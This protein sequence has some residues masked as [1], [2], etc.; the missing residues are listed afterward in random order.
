MSTPRTTL[1]VLPGTLNPEVV[2]KHN[3]HHSHV[4]QK[5]CRVCVNHGT[6]WVEVGFPKP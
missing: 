1:L 3:W 2:R 4:P 6:V 5:S